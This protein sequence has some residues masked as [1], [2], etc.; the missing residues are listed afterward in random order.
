[1]VDD[2]FAGK[3]IPDPQ[4]S[5]DDGQTSAE[6]AAAFNDFAAGHITRAQLF[7][8]LLQ[9]RVFVPVKA[10]LDS[11]GV[12]DH[13]HKVEKDS[14]MA[15]VSIQA[16]DGRKA[17]LA[18]TATSNM[19]AWDEQARPIAAHFATAIA[20]ALDEGADALLVDFRT[21]HQIAVTR[22]EML[23]VANQLP[24]VDPFDDDVAMAILSEV[25]RTIGTQH[26]VT[27]EVS[28][29]INGADVAIALVGAQ[30]EQA[31]AIL[32]EVATGLNNREELRLRLAGGIALSIK[33]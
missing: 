20:A 26:E 23:L 29:A 25:L 33:Q 4:F 30:T 13:G 7:E 8:T 1:M 5:G 18:F 31:D 3:S 2:R 12:D 16:A 32:Q 14:H 6:V 17:L 11:H 27:F 15:T 10:I 22:R 28:P 9:S 21:D 24:V 19:S